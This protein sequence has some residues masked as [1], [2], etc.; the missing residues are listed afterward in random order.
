M[1][2]EKALEDAIKF[3][4]GV[5]ALAEELGISQAAVSQWE[6]VPPLQ[7]IAVE[8]ATKGRV[9]RYKLRPDIYPLEDASARK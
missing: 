9:T 4:G 6:R 1:A 3:A 7:V 5:G 8:K 2:R